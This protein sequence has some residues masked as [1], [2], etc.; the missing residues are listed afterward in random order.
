MNTGTIFFELSLTFYFAA[1]LISIIAFFKSGKTMEKAMLLLV[2]LGFILHTLSIISRY[3]TARYIPIT[4]PMRQHLFFMVQRAFLFLI[5]EL[6]YKIGLLGSFIMPIIFVLMLS[7]SMLS[8]GIKALSRCF[9]VIGSLAIRCAQAAMGNAAFAMAFGI[10]IMYLVQEHYLKS[11]HP[12]R[13]V[14]EASEP[15]KP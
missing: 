14:P 3:A 4:T 10:G 9:K 12:Q 2:V 15:A 6:R 1:T 5:L 7:S 11:K 13:I 8:R